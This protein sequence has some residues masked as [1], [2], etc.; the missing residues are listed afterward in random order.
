MCANWFTL[1]KTRN[2]LKCGIFVPRWVLEVQQGS[3]HVRLAK[4]HGGPNQRWDFDTD[5]TI[6]CKIGKVLDICEER[7]QAGTR[8]IAYPKHRKWNQLFS[9]VPA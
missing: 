3:S 4:A 9:M 5:S 2:I 8:V 1:L 6:K 7:T